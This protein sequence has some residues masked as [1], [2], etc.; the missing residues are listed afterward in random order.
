MSRLSFPA[1]ARFY[2][3]LALSGLLMTLQQPVVTAAISRTAGARESLAA[4]GLALSIAVFLESPI[5]MLLATGA[6]LARDRPSFRLLQR[7][8]AVTGATL[9]GVVAL[10]AFTPLGQGLFLHVLKAPQPVATQALLALR[11]LLPWPMVVAW[12]RF[13][14]GVLIRR[15]Q[16]RAVGYGTAGRLTVIAIAAFS[17]VYLA[18]WPG[19][20]A[21]TGALLVGA[22]VEALFV[23]GWLQLAG[24]RPDA[25]LAGFEPLTLSRLG[26]FYWPLA[27]TSV[28][29]VLSWPLTNAGLG[30]AAAPAQSLATWPVVLSMLWLFTTPLQML[31]QMT[32]ALVVDRS[33]L[34]TVRCF[35]L[36]LGGAASGLLALSAF[37]PLLEFLLLRVLAVPAEITGFIVPAVGLLVSLPFL[38]AAQGFYQGLLISRKRTGE[39]RTA[40]GANLL[41]LIGVLAA[42]IQQGTVPGSLLAASAMTAGLLTEASLLWWKASQLSFP[43]K[44]SRTR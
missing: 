19:A 7:F 3:P 15:G 12:R 41:T 23:T 27:L 26:R 32:I 29:T 18:N 30:R 40:M 35:A 6:A 33:S 28:L 39:V 34:R 10:L 11:I 31:Q 17:M 24:K 37:T 44:S 21:G 9:A 8:T 38:T 36:G 4:Y 20:A 2:L 22:L 5:Q 43:M 25:T 1:L 42:G 13:Y 16:T 14:Q